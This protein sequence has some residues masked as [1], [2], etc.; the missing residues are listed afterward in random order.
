MH[1][2]FTLEYV[3]VYTAEYSKERGNELKNEKDKRRSL[4]VEE[5]SGLEDSLEIL[6][7]EEN[8]AFFL[9]GFGWW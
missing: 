6:D 1:W 2:K 8:L 4:Q 3:D 9:S 5:L 7:D